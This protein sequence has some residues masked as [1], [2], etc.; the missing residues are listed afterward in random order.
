MCKCVPATWTTV[1]SLGDLS[2]GCRGSDGRAPHPLRPPQVA[3]LD[4]WQRSQEIG[5]V[6]FPEPCGPG[7][8]RPGQERVALPPGRDSITF[9]VAQQKRQ[10]FP[11]RGRSCSLP[12][13]CRLPEPR[14]HRRLEASTTDSVASKGERGRGVCLGSLLATPSPSSSPRVLPRSGGRPGRFAQPAPPPPPRPA[15][16]PR[17]H[18]PEG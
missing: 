13:S 2:L 15:P 18:H 4:S 9:P 12:F 11:C 17:S 3:K 8:G 16:H 7:T 1:P 5:P 6:P 14:L 10:F